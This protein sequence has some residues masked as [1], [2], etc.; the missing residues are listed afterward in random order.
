[1]F[2]KNSN[3][4]FIIFLFHTINCSLTVNEFLKIYHSCVH[5]VHG[6]VIFLPPA[7]VFTIATNSLLPLQEHRCSC[8]LSLRHNSFKR[9]TLRAEVV[10]L[11]AAER[12]SERSEDWPTNI[13]H[14]I[15]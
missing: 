9:T 2:F 6:G 15:L 4:Q 5:G 11:F 7:K 3:F 12:L 14:W 8:S 13:S 1:M 10:M